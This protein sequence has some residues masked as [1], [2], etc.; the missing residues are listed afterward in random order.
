MS[1]ATWAGVVALLTWVMGGTLLGFVL[2]PHPNPVTVSR[3][4]QPVDPHVDLLAGLNAVRIGRGVAPI[5]YDPQL[6]GLLEAQASGRM[7]LAELLDR[8]AALCAPA[9][10]V[11]VP[12]PHGE[13]LAAVLRG[14]ADSVIGRD[15]TQGV[16]DMLETDAGQ[17]A[18]YRVLLC[19]PTS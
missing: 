2:A 4:D 9:R 15:Y 5:E 6:A 18:S 17:P 8:Q 16:V 1:R 19:R 14:R 3:S 11:V 12:A 7:T 13:S 10:W